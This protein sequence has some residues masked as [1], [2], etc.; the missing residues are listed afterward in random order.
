[1]VRVL[2]LNLWGYNNPHDYTIRR[3]TTRGAI[4]GSAAATQPAP[5]GRSWPLHEAGYHPSDHLGLIA[6]VWWV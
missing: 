3:N 1:M 5:G 2:T 6:D 4:P